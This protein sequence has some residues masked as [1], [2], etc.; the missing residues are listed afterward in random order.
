MSDDRV[1]LYQQLR[2][3]IA[4]LLGLDVTKLTASQDVQVSTI[5]SLRL[6]LDRLQTAQ[7]RGEPSDARAL[8]SVGEALQDALRP[9]EA[10][11]RLKERGEARAKLRALIDATLT[12]RE[13][14]EASRIEQLEAENA[15]LREQLAQASAVS[16]PA[17]DPTPPVAAPAVPEAETVVP[18]RRELTPGEYA[19]RIKQS[20]VNRPEDPGVA[21]AK[22]TGLHWARKRWEPPYGW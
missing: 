12:A 1:E 6:E 15:E 19:E 4:E 17:A 22:G 2:G 11:L 13:E 8:L 21:Y 5:A 3:S 14:A 18:L 16:P 7:L 9:A 20:M 10:P